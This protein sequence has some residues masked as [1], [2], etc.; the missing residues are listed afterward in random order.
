MAMPTTSSNDSADFVCIVLVQTSGCRGIGT[1]DDLCLEPF[2]RLC[3]ASFRSWP[4]AVIVSLLFHSPFG[5]VSRKTVLTLRTPPMSIASAAACMLARLINSTI[6]LCIGSV[7]SPPSFAFFAAFSSVAGFVHGLLGEGEIICLCSRG[8][9]H[10]G[11]SVH[12][13]SSGKGDNSVYA[14]GAPSGEETI[15][16]FGK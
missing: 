13:G 6:T 9:L 15:F 16:V 2:A 4:L 14:H 10:E 7:P 5:A 8:L 12:G 1:D 3:N 11:V